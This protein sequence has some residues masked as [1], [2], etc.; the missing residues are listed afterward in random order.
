MYKEGWKVEVIAD[1][2]GK[3]CTNSLWFDTPEKAK[4]YG[5]DLA[6]RWTMVEEWRVVWSTE[7]ILFRNLTIKEVEEFRQHARDNDPENLESWEVYHPLCREEWMTRG[8]RPP[9]EGAS[10]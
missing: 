9:M 5:A 1:S 4:A 10:I 7:N 6:S 8:I 2:S 3:W